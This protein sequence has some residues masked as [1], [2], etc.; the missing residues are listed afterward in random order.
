MNYIF[1][2][3]R[4]ITGKDKENFSGPAV[5][6]AI[7]AIALGL[8]VMIISVAVLTGFQQQIRDKV[9][10]FGAHIQIDNFGAN[11]SFEANPVSKKQDFYPDITDHEGIEHIQVF[12]YKAGI[13]K[14]EDQI[15]GVVMKGIG[16]DFDWKYFRSN[17]VDGDI[18]EISDSLKS[19]EVLISRLQAAKLE[20]AVGD[21]LR[22]YFLGGSQAQPRGRKFSIS[23]IYETGLED[24]DKLY[25]IGDIAHIQKLN[26]WD[27][28][29]VSGF[30][31]FINDFDRLDELG[32]YVYDHVDYTL[33]VQTVREVYP[34]IFDWLKLLDKNVIV[35]LILMILVSGITMISTLLILVLD[36]T[37][38]IGV[39][40][41]L[42][43]RNSSIRK[44][45][46]VNASMIIGKGLF[47]GNLAGILICVVQYYF[48]IIPLD[49][50]SYFV[51]WVPVKISIT[52]ILLINAGTFLVC[53]LMLLIPSYVI[54]KITPMKAIRF[55]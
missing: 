9:V 25:V 6:T 52:Y 11:A 49:Q 47:W 2:I 39:L 27:H 8:S 18:F 42:G 31:I 50:A 34:Q 41:A 12:A 3:A 48:R 14:V 35:I 36:R 51:S 55:R 33:N 19:N 7:V 17:I 29:Q 16:N 32:I 53:L 28:D 23:G 4:R 21:D 22:M 20:L 38:M 45:F 30:E 46:L 40:K 26:N 13:I 44:L 24:F 43:M 15:Q 5:K 54:T 1:Y 37:S 10:G